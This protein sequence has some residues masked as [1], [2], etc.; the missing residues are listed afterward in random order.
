MV[1]PRAVVGVRV[2][3]VRRYAARSRARF[4]ARVVRSSSGI[5]CSFRRSK[6]YQHHVKLP[7]MANMLGL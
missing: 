5:G 4:A 1:H 3:P 6:V 7:H 2:A